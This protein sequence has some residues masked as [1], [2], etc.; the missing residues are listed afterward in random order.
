MRHAAVFA[1]LLSPLLARA[2]E[3]TRPW[4]PRP[5][6]WPTIFG[7]F[8]N[9]SSVKDPKFKPPFR[10]K[11]ATRIEGQMKS[12]PVVA[13]G[14]VFAQTVNGLLTAMDQE[15]GRILWR[16]YYRGVLPSNGAQNRTSPLYADG[17]LYFAYYPGGFYCVDATTGEEIWKHAEGIRIG[18]MRC[19]ALYHEGMVFYPF[20]L[21]GERDKKRFRY[22]AYKAF[23]AA[24]GREV[25]SKEFKEFENKHS[26]LEPYP[27]VSTGCIGDGV[28]Y[29][30]LG[31]TA[32]KKQDKGYLLALDPKTGEEIWRNEENFG[33]GRW[34]QVAFVKGRLYIGGGLRR[35]PEKGFRCVD[36]KTGKLVWQ[37]EGTG[38]F[39]GAVSAKGVALRTYGSPASV[40]DLA[41]GKPIAGKDGKPVTFGRGGSTGCSPVIIVND[42]WGIQHSGGERRRVT[43][44]RIDRTENV[45]EFQLAGRACP[46][47]AVADG[48]IFTPSGG[49]GLVYCFEP[50]D[51][52]KRP[53]PS[54][55]S[56]AGASPGA[57]KIGAAD[58]PQYK[59]D[60]ART[61]STPSATFKPPLA[62]K[63]AVK[64]DA[65]CYA[66]PAVMDGKV[67]VV[68][69]SGTAYCIN[70]AAGKVLWKRATGGVNNRSS[71]VAAG[72]RV[73]FGST[74]RNFY[75]LN[76]ADGAVVK[77][78][79]MPDVV[80]SAPALEG[81]RLYVLSFDGTLFCL[82]LDAN[83]LWTL[84]LKPTSWWLTTQRIAQAPH[85]VAA[86]GKDVLAVAGNSLFKVRDEGKSGRVVWTHPGTWASGASIAGEALFIGNAPAEQEN[87]ALRCLLD[88]KLTK[89]SSGPNGD[90]KNDYVRGVWG[91][92][93]V[94]AAPSARGDRAVFG[95]VRGAFSG[96]DLSGKLARSYSSP[97]I[98]W[99]TA[100]FERPHNRAIGPVGFVGG[101]ALAKEHAV[102]GGLDGRVYVVPLDA[103]G[104][105]L[106]KIAPKA[107]A[108]E[109][110]GAPMVL[111]TPAVSGGTAYVTTAD[112]FLYGLSGLAG[113]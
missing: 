31:H 96:V 108:L 35:A 82:D 95:S 8:Q 73:Y 63:C 26:V 32:K 76:A 40:Y 57:P 62:L 93:R 74:D 33:R 70:P 97:P 56:H 84:H 78:L 106:D 66:S 29:V 4:T 24:T 11:W 64:L 68:D 91:V 37:S 36:A 60:A 77:K 22:V 28:L 19:S 44:G 42:E 105:G 30:T 99:S 67:F 49:D 61:G 75:V 6:D 9:T 41:T 107:F 81:G 112:G 21:V 45:W 87:Q 38:I 90:R 27:P 25:W 89:R 83:V 111:S 88:D 51:G 55:A 20:W 10:L 16:K 72:G 109:L 18:G 2:G 92:G 54:Y 58:W 34:P 110:P 86:R 39:A 12:T 23:D 101:A 3:E 59:F 94:N 43:V 15:T 102:F 65:P 47:S 46:G 50:D 79:P 14:R 5:G 100:R 71:P 103:R 113:R 52:K 85:D 17:R 48:C 53:A 104:K 69:E 98:V 7:N 80:L 13:D 1:L